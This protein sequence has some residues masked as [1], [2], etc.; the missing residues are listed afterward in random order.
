MD[1][2]TSAKISTFTLNLQVDNGICLQS[3]NFYYLYYVQIW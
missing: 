2:L 1:G 3:K